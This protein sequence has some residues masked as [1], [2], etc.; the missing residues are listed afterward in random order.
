[1]NERKKELKK[2]YQQSDKPMGIYQIRNQVNGKIFIGYAQDL[3]AIFNSNRFQLKM[4]G[5]TNKALQKE[6]NEFGEVAFVFE[7]LDELKPKPG[8][9]P[10]Y[11]S[12]LKELHQLWLDN[13]EPYGEKGYHA[14]PISREERLAMMAK[15]RDGN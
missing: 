7:I 8:Q 3:Q 6:W 2:S 15:N 11:L 1:M 13:L 9:S 4:N 14:K 5:H 12:E 10:N